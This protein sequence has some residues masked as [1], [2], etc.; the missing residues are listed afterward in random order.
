VC[1][2]LDV[3]SGRLFYDISS[4]RLFDLDIKMDAQQMRCI[5]AKQRY[6]R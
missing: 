6:I 2:Y 3:D 5:V 4:C 1:S